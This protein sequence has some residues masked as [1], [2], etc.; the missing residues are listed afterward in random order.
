MGKK[1]TGGYIGQL[2]DSQKKALAEM[3]EKFADWKEK[4]ASWEGA[5]FQLDDRF[6]LKFL[7]ARDFN[8]EKASDMLTKHLEFREKWMPHTISLED[9]D[10]KDALLV[11]TWRLAGET[12]K[13]NPVQLIQV[14]KFI[15]KEV[16]SAEQYTRNVLLHR[17]LTL[18]K[19]IHDGWKVETSTVMFDSEFI[20]YFFMKKSLRC[21]SF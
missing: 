20:I 17:E 5:V 10:V 9:P 19:L 18:K 14:G 2:D 13:G 6:I 16:E 4:M 21:L 1:F 11:G 3:H 7:R 15:P 12:L 8:V